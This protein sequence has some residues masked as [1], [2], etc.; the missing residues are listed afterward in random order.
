MESSNI[1]IIQRFQ[2][3]VLR[4]IVDAPWYTRNSDLH[5]DL[6]A[7]SVVEEIEKSA[8]SHQT[9]LEAHTNVEALQLLNNS[10]IVRRLKRTKPFE[11]VK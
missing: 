4:S 2:N 11:L 1:Q 10:N 9:R 6:K 5:K 8:K 3:K 7:D